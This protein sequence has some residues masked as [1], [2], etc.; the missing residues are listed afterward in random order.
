MWNQTHVRTRFGDSLTEILTFHTL[1]IDIFALTTVKLRVAGSLNRI[2][3]DKVKNNIFFWRNY[4]YFD[5]QV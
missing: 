1:E 2:N 3:Q 4:F 5:A